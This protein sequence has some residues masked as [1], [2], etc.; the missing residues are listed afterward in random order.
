MLAR[1]AFVLFSLGSITG[2]AGCMGGASLPA[3]QT[4][5]PLSVLFVSAPPTSLAV[6]ASATL[7]AA[8]TFPGYLP[9]GS[10]NNFV[11]WS[12]TCGS[13]GGCGSFSANADANGVTYTA[14]SAIPTGS[15][16]TVTATSIATPA[17]SASATIAI[18]APIPISVSFFVPPPAS[19]QVNSSTPLLAA[20]ANDVSAAPR[21]QWTVTCNSTSCGS[22]SSTATADEV[23]T[24]YTAP[25]AIPPGSTVTVT[26]TSL[27]D[28]T[29]SVSTTIVITPASPNLANGTY[30]FQL[31][32]QTGSQASF[33]TGVFTAANGTITGGEQDWNYFQS[34]ANDDL[35][36]YPLTQKI[37]GGS[38]A[39]TSDGNIQ[40]SL[41][42]GAGQ[43]ETLTGALASAG[44]GFVAA[45]NGSPGNGTLDMQTST[46][47]PSGG[48]VLSLYGGDQ[49]GDAAWIAGILNVD[50]SGGI[51]GNGS[52]LDAVDGYS[53]YG[54]THSVGVSTVSAPDAYG[55]VL[56]QL[57]PGSGS[58]LPSI[59]LAGYVVD[60]THIRLVETNDAFDNTNFQ[61]VMGGTA[62]GQGA[63]TGKFTAA[64][65]TGSTYVFAA[66]G[67]DV[68]GQ[69]QLAG[70]LTAGAS[71]TITGT[72]NWNDLTN[73]VQSPLPF[74]GTYTVDPTGRVT[75]SKIVG[76]TF[77]Y[78]FHLYLT[79]DGNG[80]LLSND[81]ADTFNGQVIQQQASPFTSAS[82]SGT[83]G[84]NDS[85]YAI[86]KN[87]GTL[88]P[89]VANGSILA[90]AGNST[91]AIAGFADLGDGSAN[92]ALSG[93]ATPSATGILEGTIAGFNPASRTTAGSFTL[94]LADGTQGVLI[95]TDSGQL[96]LGH[97]QLH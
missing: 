13:P 79:G 95:Q 66:Q 11:T 69:L 80:L 34:D 97:F 38:Y 28:S 12:L 92:F 93:S 64:S 9:T 50:S 22:F 74:T 27:T 29:K 58:T 46:A 1:K 14:P 31:S 68:R 18:V 55:R 45:I 75:V 42:L 37:T 84:L 36:P 91:N 86:V 48:Y 15:T 59:Y 78:S 6:Q 10:V 61:G 70:L 60:A 90:T 49:Y 32:G 2:L 89:A 65:V 62:L 77:G 67:T 51:S 94:Y 85:T 76:S 17:K 41:Q 7:V 20:I 71:G 23:G 54:G 56:F 24:T 21:V 19:L 52:I 72:L 73:T 96:N 35:V 33:F 5:Q 30:V 26:A 8:A 83:Y 40:V 63:N 3:S 16:V 53:G 47:A 43:A 87:L 82:F 88:Q 4:P 25:A 44:R 57:R 39:T 81:T